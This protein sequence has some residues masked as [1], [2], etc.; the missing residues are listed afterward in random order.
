VASTALASDRGATV[1]VAVN[2]AGRRRHVGRLNWSAMVGLIVAGNLQAMAQNRDTR[3]VLN[4]F[5]SVN[6]LAPTERP[7]TLARRKPA[8][9]RSISRAAVERRGGDR[10]NSRRGR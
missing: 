3:L 5:G 4:W 1:V 6:R 9:R 8:T 2:T 10:R 7:A